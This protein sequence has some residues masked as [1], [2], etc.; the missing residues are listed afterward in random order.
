MKNKIKSTSCGNTAVNRNSHFSISTFSSAGPK[1]TLP[2]NTTPTGTLKKAKRY[3]RTPTRQVEH[4]VPAVHGRYHQEGRQRHPE[5]GTERI[6]WG[7][8][9]R[10]VVAPRQSRHE[11]HRTVTA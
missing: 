5:D 4:A 9:E 8:T 10:Q 11:R 1:T 6:V 3:H 7:Q 2:H